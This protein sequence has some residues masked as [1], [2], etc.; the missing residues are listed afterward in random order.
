M[1]QEH[2]S[3]RG[4][5]VVVLGFHE[6][7]KTSLINTLLNETGSD[8]CRKLICI[9]TPGWWRKYPLSDTAD[10]IKQ[11]IILSVN[12]CLPGPHAF[13]LIID[14]NNV[15]FTE[16]IRKSVE[17]HLG[18]FGERVW[19]H[20]IVV[21]TCGEYLKG[22]TIE[23]HI[24]SEGEAL[25]WVVEK[26]GNR[27]HMFNIESTG[28]CNEV[29]ENKN[30]LLEQIDGL[31]AKYGNSSFELEK[32]LREVEEKRINHQERAKMR[33]QKVMDKREMLRKYG[34]IPSLSELRILLLGW[35][36]SGKTSA[37]DTILGQV[38]RVN[39]KR[40]N[41]SER[42]SKKV[43]GRQVSVV[44]TP[45]WWKY[46][47]AK[48]TPEWVTTEL[49]RG[50]TLDSKAP[51][52]I[53]LAVPADTTFHEEQRKNIEDNMKM[54]GEQVWKH[55]MVLFTC[56]DRLEDTSIEEHIE[57]E[58][59]PLQWLVEKCGN[60]YHVLSWN[61]KEEEVMELLNKIEEM[62]ASNSLFWPE[63]ES[64]TCIDKKTTE[65]LI[66]VPNEMVQF[67]DQK[68]QKMDRELEKIVTICSETTSK[69]KGSMDNPYTNFGDTH[70][71]SQDEEINSGKGIS[72][73]D[74]K[75][76]IKK[77]VFDAATGLD[78]QELVGEKSA[79][80]MERMKEMLERMKEML[81]REWG[82]RELA[83]TQRFQRQLTELR[84]SGSEADVHDLNLSYRKVVW[85]IHHG[86]SGYA[87]NEQEVFALPLNRHVHVR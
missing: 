40:T 52:A 62:V 25:K 16:K 9:D 20:T 70:P 11:K 87:S 10:F 58:G 38:D 23:Q 48:C 65:D 2:V 46:L 24:E 30:K 42:N 63:P 6:S 35:L 15:P 83:V 53:L 12:E 45:G 67:L 19:E 36:I 44:D 13:L 14:I 50:L 49:Q 32:I 3:Q 71:S 86:T 66:E 7:G 33:Q 37:K 47:P 75:S 29:N 41:K 43:A 69:L 84:E 72:P 39:K 17:E 79:G 22:T 80:Q 1:S 74:S 26:C 31:V 8:S 76:P 78:D 77:S 73:P 82:R 18:L 21:F 28:S 4:L 59:Q 60:R 64:Q 57:S 81:E 61:D 55:T 51:H 34:V 5:R 54:F 68:W 56:G 85:W 27:C